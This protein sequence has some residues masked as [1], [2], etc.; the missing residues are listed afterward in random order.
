MSLATQP[1]ERSLVERAAGGDRLALEELVRLHEHRIAGLCRARLRSPADVD[2]AVQETFILALD[3]IHQLRDPNAFGPWLRTIAARVCVNIL[4]DRSR[5][6]TSSL[7][8]QTVDGG[9]LPDELLEMAEDSRRVHSALDRLGER[10]RQ[11]LWLRH[12]VEAPISR[13]AEELGV[14]EGSA[15]VLLT[16]ARKRLRDAT[17]GLPAIVPLP[18]RR[19]A[20]TQLDHLAERPD[21]AVTFGHLAAVA[22]LVLLPMAGPPTTSGQD[23]PVQQI[24]T[25]SH[26]ASLDGIDMAT[27]D[28]TLSASGHRGH[29]TPDPVTPA[30]PPDQADRPGP[31]GRIVNDI[32]IKNEYPEDQEYLVEIQVFA[33]E[34]GSEGNTLR[35]YGEPLDDPEATVEDTVGGLLGE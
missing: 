33:D 27:G 20:R 11:A 34:S 8:D 7:D 5:R 18:W 10:D 2:D 25:K 17:S 28:D 15:R 14:T 22:G 21:V 23:Q 32:E 6:H 13:V 16:R 12:G 29:V 1:T 24:A 35:L 3:R 9:P 31:V 19:W 4:R 26:V 30:E